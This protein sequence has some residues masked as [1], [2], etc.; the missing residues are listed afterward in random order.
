[1]FSIPLVQRIVLKE[2]L[3]LFCLIVLVMVF[4][5]LLL[6]GNRMESFFT[7]IE[8]TVSDIFILLLLL[9]P[10]LLTFIFPIA[11]ML[12][13]FLVFFRMVADKELVALRACG[14]SIIQLM[15]AVC[16]FGIF[17]SGIS[18]WLFLYAVPQGTENFQ[19]ALN[20][21]ASQR[22]DI[23]I[24]PGVFY[25]KIPQTTLFV[26]AVDSDKTMHTVF[27]EQQEIGGTTITI[28]ADKGK[29]TIN[30]EEQ[31]LF[32]TLEN[33]KLYRIEE[34][35][36]LTSSFIRY[37]L[38]LPLHN[39]IRNISFS[40]LKYDNL[41][42][43]DLLQRIK[44]YKNE[45]SSTENTSELQLLRVEIQRRFVFPVACFILALFTIPLATLSNASRNVVLIILLCAFIIYYGLMLFTISLA[46]TSI[47]SPSLLWLPNIL[48]AF[49]TLRGLYYTSKEEGASLLFK[50]KDYFSHFFLYS[51][52]RR[53]LS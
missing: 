23:I 7:G 25:T 8:V 6:Q 29:I 12:S 37:T 52:K 36:Y 28:L 47:I 18:L 11:T 38:T 10:Y 14:I 32:L 34:N 46:E 19:K 20:S 2:L 4:F 13:V 49:L 21:L 5:L 45:G 50:I 35:T 16:I 1:M 3:V 26:E 44:Q 39:I 9:M 27:L 40:S 42:L 15:P 51:I 30:P 31:N 53:N 43:E 17:A 33:G 48:Y 24:I 41:S 22:A